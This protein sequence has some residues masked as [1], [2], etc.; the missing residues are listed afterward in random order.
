MDQESQIQ[1]PYPPNIY[2]PSRQESHP[3]TFRINL[4]HKS[5][6]LKKIPTGYSLRHLPC[7]CSSWQPVEL[8]RR[9]DLPLSPL[10]NLLLPLCLTPELACGSV[11]TMSVWVRQ[12]CL[13]VWASSEATL[14]SLIMVYFT[15]L[16]L[17]RAL[18][19]VALLSDWTRYCQFLA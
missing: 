3:R 15:L 8:P 1:S 2:G 18:L 16:L 17:C 9:S 11:N 19:L 7:S 14:S 13:S 12:H 5:N 6:D 10:V 4:C